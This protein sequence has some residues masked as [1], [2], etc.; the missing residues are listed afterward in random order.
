M[1]HARLDPL[2]ARDDLVCFHLG[3]PHSTA[4]LQNTSRSRFSCLS[5]ARPVVLDLL[6]RDG[7]HIELFL[8]V[9]AV[10]I[11]PDRNREDWASNQAA[12]ADTAGALLINQSGAH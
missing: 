12:S 4:I 5:L 8:L 2:V 9:L 7:Q 6:Q 11:D 1:L 3:S 10:A